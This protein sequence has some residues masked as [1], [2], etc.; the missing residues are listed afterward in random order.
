MDKLR[1]K[2]GIS[3]ARMMFDNVWE[4]RIAYLKTQV[5]LP[6]KYG[7]SMEWKSEY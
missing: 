5:G 4:E 7:C 1:I 6:C 2:G 3:W